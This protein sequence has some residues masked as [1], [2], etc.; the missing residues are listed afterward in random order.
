MPRGRC[1]YCGGYSEVRQGSGCD[2]CTREGY[3]AGDKLPK[4]LKAAAEEAAK[5]W[6]LKEPSVDD[7]MMELT[8]RQDWDRMHADLTMYIVNCATGKE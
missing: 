3:L 8:G 6:G 4:K 7:V 1:I 5:R 2:S